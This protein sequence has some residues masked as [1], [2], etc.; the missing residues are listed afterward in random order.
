MNNWP[1]ACFKGNWIVLVT[2]VGKLCCVQGT[3][4][5]LPEFP[6]KAL[7]GLSWIWGEDVPVQTFAA[8]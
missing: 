2:L 7:N 3:H 6:P 4:G 1:Q 5:S 8:N